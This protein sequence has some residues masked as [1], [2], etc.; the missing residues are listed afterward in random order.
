MAL[1]VGQN[2]PELKAQI[3]EMLNK[4]DLDDKTSFSNK[5]IAFQTLFE[6]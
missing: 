4:D 6:T 1:E 5:L 2:L 3:A